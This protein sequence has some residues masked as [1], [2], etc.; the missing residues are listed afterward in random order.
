MVV[1]GFG[2]EDLGRGGASGIEDRY[3]DFKS[4]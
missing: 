3:P 1:V 2:S 4:G